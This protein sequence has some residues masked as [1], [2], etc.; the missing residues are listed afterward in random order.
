MANAKPLVIELFCGSFG[1]SAGFIDQG[2]RAIGFDI[3]HEPYHGPVP[4]G[5]ELVLQDVLTLSGVQF[6]DA[7]VIVCSPPC[8]RYSYM[9]MPWSRAKNLAAWYRGR[10][11]TRIHESDG[12]LIE[13]IEPVDDPCNIE[14]FARERQAELNALFNACFRIQ[15][16]ASEA[17]GRYIPMV[18]ENVKGAQPWVGAAKAH[19]GSFY[20]W[21]DIASVNGMVVVGKPVFGSV[22]K[23]QGGR[24]TNSKYQH[25]GSWKNEQGL[26]WR[27]PQNVGR[28]NEG[29]SWFAIGS[30]GQTNVGQNPDGRKIDDANLTGMKAGNGRNLHVFEKTGK[31][32]P[33]FTTMSINPEFGIKQGGEWWHDP[34]SMTQRFSSKSL[35]RKAA[36]AA[37]AR[38]PF[39][40]ARFVA[41]CFRDQYAPACGEIGTKGGLPSDSATP[42]ESA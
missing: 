9:A 16:E 8:Q 11:T 41:K 20:F 28:K 1:W 35:N 3:V 6:K 17:A 30:P 19:Y 10:T 33:N 34:E 42:F 25:S 36:S 5:A 21:G 27:D 40:L 32:T 2:F 23:A 4:E 26:D 14:R 7:S 24:K 12:K 38:I 29:W 37:I 13:T 15:R 31:P 18:V 39:P 22:L